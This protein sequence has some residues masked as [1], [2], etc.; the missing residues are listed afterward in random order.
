MKLLFLYIFFQTHFHSMKKFKKLFLILLSLIIIIL[1]VI[2]FYLLST[3]PSYEGELKLKNLDKETTTYF[4][5]FGVPH[6]YANSEK[7]AMIA[8]GYIHAQDRLWQME[9]LKRIAPGRLSEIF[10]S[11][12]LKNDIF[13]SGLGIDEASEKAIA[14]LDKNSQTYKLTLAYLDGVNQYIEN[15]KTPIEFTLLGIK[16]QKMTVKDVYNIFGFMSFSF[17]MAQKTDPLLTDIRDEFGM[18]YLK[19]F[20]IDG[21]LGTKQLKTFNGKSKEY[22][23]ISKSVAI[24]LDNSPAAPFIGS[25]SWVI[26]AEKTKN[27][28]VIFENDPHIGFSQPGTWYEAH[29]VTPNYEMYGYHLAGTPFPLLGHNR[30]YAYGLTMF[31]NDDLDFFQEEENP[32]NSNQYK[33]LTGFSDYKISTKRIKVKDSSEVTIKLKISQH[34]PIMSGLI[35][36]L[37]NK[38]PVALSWIYTQHKNQIVEATYSMSRA[39]SLDDFKNAIQ[40]IH[41]PG[42]NIMYGDAK[43]NIAWITSGKLYKVE[44]SVN[45]NF[46][47][48]GT[49]GIDDK[50]EFIDFENH[51]M[52]INPP[53][54]YVYSS[55][56]Q[57]QAIH[58]YLYPGYYLPKDRAT[59]IDDLL[60]TKNDWTKYDVCKMTLDNTSVVQGN[61]AQK[62]ISI[63]DQKVI[64]ENEK[65]AISILKNWKGTNNLNDVAPTIY[66]KLIYFYLENTFKDELGADHFKALLITHIIKQTIE[67]QINNENSPWW[68]LV[69]TA[70]KKET[71]KEI[72][73]K[74]FHQ[75]ITSLQNQLGNDVNLWSWNR[76][77]T[78]EIEHPLGKVKLLKPLFNVNSGSIAGTSE[79]INNL[80]FTFSDNPTNTIKAG[81]STRRVIDF[82][83][84]EN[85]LSIL[86]SGQS[87]NPMSKHYNDQAEM[88]VQGKF[89]KM[90]MNTQEIIK[91][92]TKLVFKPKS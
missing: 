39:K 17:A 20:G 56:N 27:G 81:P 68:D 32:K 62:I 35:D 34:G 77:H 10:G 2:Y 80:M 23:E 57:T 18:N 4:D 1:G 64:S 76:V 15:G 67:N 29:I 75:A 59:R 71:R 12:M 19:D 51:P 90:K 41:A 49:N 42:L 70:N 78:L 7:D 46:I 16:K 60:A 58:N 87:G 82:S 50:K 86:P 92:S 48:N 40:L 6:I 79:V 53:W 8:L 44:K 33:T 43:N 91:T 13:F 73:T 69:S 28:K 38:K 36:G 55:N 26:G 24:L 84:I 89:R 14:Q 85:S 21:A 25:N 11:V 47:L 31:E 72:L 5:D 37:S 63:I 61:V 3:K 66:N 65:T 54:N 9:L 88:Y 45:T 30:N 22:A 52:A 83:D 74:S